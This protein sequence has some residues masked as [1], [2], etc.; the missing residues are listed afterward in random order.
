[1]NRTLFAIL[2]LLFTISAISLVTFF[3]Y[4][5][6]LGTAFHIKQDE[7]TVLFAITPWG[8]PR[9]AKEAYKP[10]LKYLSEKTGKKFLLLTMEDYNS[11]IENIAEGNIDLAIVSPVSLVHIK[12]LNPD[13]QYIS[14]VARKH[15]GTLSAAYKGYIVALKAKYRGW[16]FDNFLKEPKE[17]A[18]GF[19]MKKSSSGWAY[20]MAMMKRRGINPYE[21]FKK[22][23][24]F[25]NHPQVTDAIA[26]GKVTLGATWEYN[27]EQAQKKYGDIFEII[28]TTEDIP[29][30]SWVASSRVDPKLV[31]KIKE[32]QSEINNSS[33]KEELLK[34]T[35]DKG[36]IVLGDDYYNSVRDVIKYVGDF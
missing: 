35:P 23:T 27:L 16:R 7:N 13:I 6:K 29:G 15:G 2:A 22:V 14:T 8:D 5:P 30:L 36:W 19:V 34:E 33:S 17:H 28:Y 25:E 26:K 24:E 1:M 32:I 9:Q 10:L 18:V 4:S 21:T 31:N 11:A 20:P 3:G 12:E